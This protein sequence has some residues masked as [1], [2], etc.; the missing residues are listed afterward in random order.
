M[1]GQDT[2]QTFG[3]SRVERQL[4]ILHL[5]D[6]PADAE[7]IQARLAADG[8]PSETVR[9]VTRAEFEAA[10]HSRQFDL[11]LADHSLPAFD[12]LT[13]LS[14]AQAACPE[15]PFI[16]VTGAMG[17]DH[18]VETLA[19]GAT[20]YVLKGR[21]ARLAPAAR[22][23]LHE[24][25]DRAERRR[26]E[27][28][29]GRQA[30]RLTRLAEASQVF[31]AATTD[32]ARLL[33]VICR[34]V[35]VLTGDACMLWLLSDDGRWLNLVSTYHPHPEAQS[36]EAE[37]RA[38]PLPVPADA[39]GQ[40][41]DVT[42]VLLLPV[43]EPG[44]LEGLTPPRLWPLLQRFPI[45]SLAAV[46]LPISGRVIGALVVSRLYPGEP[47]SEVDKAFLQDLADHAA[48]AIDNAR[49]YEHEQAARQAAEL[50]ARHT[51]RLQ[52][53]TAALSQALTPSQVAD[54]ILHQGLNLLDASAAALLR[55]SDDGQ[56]L[57]RMT[58]VGYPAQ[59]SQQ[60]ERYPITSPVPAAD[61]ARS[62]EGI[63]IESA[64]AFQARYPQLAPAIAATGY[65]AA[66]AV[67]L[68]Y[69]DRTLG[70][71]ALSFSRA[72][73]FDD[74]IQ[75]F[76]L[77]LAGQCAQALERA[78]LFIAEQEA[79]HQAEA[80][81]ERLEFLAEAGA[82]LAASLDYTATL[83][84][85]AQ[86]LVPYL[87]DWCVVDLLDDGSL[88]QVA[89]AHV[90]PGKE[91]LVRRLRSRYP[92]DLNE[93]HPILQ[94]IH[95]ARPVVA[96][97]IT[98]AD[99][100]ARAVDEQH[101]DLLLQLDI[102]AHVVVPIIARGRCLGAISLVRSAGS[103]P[104]EPADVALAEEV[105]RRAGLAIDNARLF[106]QAQS[107][108]ALLEQR[109]E[110]RTQALAVA[111]EQA[112]VANAE[113]EREVLRRRQTEERFRRLLETAPDATVIVD[114]TGRIILANSQTERMFG[115]PAA[116]LLGQPVE[117]LIP[118]QFL[119]AHQQHRADFAHRP[120]RREMGI[121]MQLYGRRRDGQEFPVEISLGPLESEEGMLISCAIRDVTR[122][123]QAEDELRASHAQLQDL[124]SHMQSVREEE[125][126]R[127]AREVHDELGQQLSGLKMDVTWIERR[128]GPE[129]SQLLEKMHSMVGLIDE[130]IKT[131]RHI[132][133]E[134]RPGLLDD[135]GLVAALEW[136]LQEFANRS[137]IAARF[138]S[139][140]PE[141]PL[142]PESATAVFRV[143]QEGLTNVAR[144]A[145][146]TQ[147]EVRLTQRAPYVL[148]Q[149]EDNGRGIS[150]EALSSR[151]SLGLIGMHE[152]VRLFAGELSIEGSPGQGTTLTIKI[153]L[154]APG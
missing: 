66:A 130:A 82:A 5:E 29:L 28:Q 128:L 89:V 139:D 35:H 42:Q 97:V 77:A 26:A 148:L 117:R 24:A 45:F 104:Y 7:L 94:V 75:G 41:L 30:Q 141:L 17:E 18:A 151:K 51:A 154:G 131:V 102:R 70:V 76:I 74:D 9:V 55:V 90:D 100:A 136:Q 58:T 119:E 48:L 36:L 122:R 13:A 20:D 142:Q 98:P 103:R 114:E 99:Q 43:V 146:A 62:G 107:L 115:Y 78:R 2:Y 69:E 105:A 71:L 27:A 135:F 86:Q 111:L 22:R 126:A 40:P 16:F 83:Q 127:I 87:A 88:H 96:P 64:D 118:Q 133:T 85:V 93:L 110:E 4:R 84:T 132:A 147:V 120:H 65:E 63:W 15:V 92:P 140:L 112:R 144:H 129:Q 53:V 72:M 101:L 31:A 49:L 34:E 143:F 73:A 33:D 95:T 32:Y 23:A 8:V 50:A 125:R 109:V 25:Q 153:P 91:A 134:L 11:I 59:V 150:A 37:L 108:N 10:L 152:R 47:Y 21:L 68:R 61:A 81:R 149:I 1:A 113:L 56:S 124:M 3:V 121:G 138:R 57:I 106:G 123:K 52:A 137:G 14:L 79:Y 80:S 145:Q 54:V 19:R 67:P 46:P 38:A 116:E 12:G 60:F 6:D 39:A 44:Q